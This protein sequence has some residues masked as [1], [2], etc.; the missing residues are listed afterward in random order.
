MSK[1]SKIRTTIRKYGYGSYDHALALKD[2]ESTRREKEELALKLG[3]NQNRRKFVARSEALPSSPPPQKEKDVDMLAPVAL[4][5]EGIEVP[6]RE[7]VA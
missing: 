7:K 4:K 3:L 2:L 5:P 1:M 6:Q